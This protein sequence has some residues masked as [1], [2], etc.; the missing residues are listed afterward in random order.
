M[1]EGERVCPRF[2]RQLSVLL[3]FK[4]C[5]RGASWAMGLSEVAGSVLWG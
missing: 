1:V 2:S 4:A 5:D 3:M